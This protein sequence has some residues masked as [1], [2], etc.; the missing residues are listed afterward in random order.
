MQDDS[1]TAETRNPHSPT[2]AE[3]EAEA[4][5]QRLAV[6]ALE[7][8]QAAK[9]G[10]KDVAASA[11]ALAAYLGKEGH[12]EFADKVEKFGNH[13]DVALKGK[14]V[15]EEVALVISAGVWLADCLAC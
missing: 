4:V 12:T 15:V 7:A 5:E 13:V 14:M 6:E 1:F 8:E 11:H 10:L 3:A 9:V 2:E